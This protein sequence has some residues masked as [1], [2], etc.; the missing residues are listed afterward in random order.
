MQAI[1]F[2]NGVE[3]INCTP[4][5][6]RFLDGEKIVSA[7][8]SGYKINAR[9]EE[10]IYAETP[11]RLVKTMFRQ[12]DEGLTEIMLLRAKYPDAL[13][14]GSIISAQAYP[15]LVVGMTPAA[16]YER[17]PPAEKLMATDKFSMF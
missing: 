15:G 2:S 16:G 5:A 3:I 9:A 6:I 13:L 11:C 14:V 10:A 12:T 8:P 7:E 17:V 1:K 4:H